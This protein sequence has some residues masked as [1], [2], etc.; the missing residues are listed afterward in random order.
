MEASVVGESPK[1][2]EGKLEL[3][4]SAGTGTGGGGGGRL[5]PK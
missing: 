5:E 2:R 4:I 3:F 1:K